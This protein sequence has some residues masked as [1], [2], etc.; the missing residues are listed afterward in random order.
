[1]FQLDAEII[2]AYISL[3]AWTLWGYQQSIDRVHVSTTSNFF[4]F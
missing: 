1:M 3:R 4:Q 2:L